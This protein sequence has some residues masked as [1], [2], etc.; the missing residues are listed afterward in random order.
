MAE[1]RNRFF[2]NATDLNWQRPGAEPGPSAPP[3]P[4]RDRGAAALRA[5]ENRRLLDPDSLQ[6]DLERAQRRRLRTSQRLS[7]LEPGSRAAQ[8]LEASLATLTATIQ[9][10][11]DRLERFRLG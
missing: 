10:L 8:R 5:A 2:I 3:E 6:D 7:R 9:S 1:P 4:R 11:Q